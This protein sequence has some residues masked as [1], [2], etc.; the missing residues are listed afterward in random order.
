M[1]SNHQPENTLGIVILAAGQGSR[2]RSSLPKVLHALAGRPLLAHVLETAAALDPE[3]ILVVYGHGGDQ[4]QAAITQELPQ[5]PLAWIHQAEQ[6]GTGHALAQTLDALAGLDRVLVLYGDVP[7]IQVQTL[8]DLNTAAGTGIGLLTARLDNPGGYGRIL[9]NAKGQVCGIVEQKDASPE[10]LA[11]DEI[12]SGIMS[13]DA[14]RLPDW[15]GRIGNA[16]AQGEYYLTDVIALAVADGVPV[17]GQITGDLG[18]ILGVNDRQQLAQLE[19]L[20]Q[21]QAAQ[22]LMRAG[23]GLADPARF[24]LRGHLEHGQ[25]CRLDIDCILEGQVRLGNRV[26]IGPYC[27]I[28]DSEIADDVEILGHCH[29]QGARIGPDSRIGPFA[30]LRP[31]TELVAANHIGNFVEVKA[32]R[33]DQTSKVNH[34]SY[35]GNSQLG[36]AVNVGAGTITCNYDGAH[37]HQTLIGDNAFIGSN[38][39]LV[40]PVSIGAGATIG[41]GSVITKEAPAHQLSLT[42]SKQTTI[43]GWQRPTK[44]SK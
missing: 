8:Q 40:A 20:Y 27:Q 30:R 4:V 43:P 31:G 11:I 33:I 32:S 36:R 18:Q 9:R 1:K 41:A 26:R 28:I 37:K 6:L 29:I 14:R 13:L 17:M 24:D 44:E 39:A 5:L 35:I 7:L 42:R 3:R 10:Q 15:L 25:D 2:M 23:L 12:N 16:N 38:S 21:V 34:L 19:R 22:R